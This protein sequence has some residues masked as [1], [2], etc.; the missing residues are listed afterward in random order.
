MIRHAAAL[1][2]WSAERRRQL[3]E[4]L[5][6]SDPRQA[7]NYQRALLDGSPQD[8]PVLRAILAD[9]LAAHN[10]R[11][12]QTT[13]D[14]LTQRDPTN[15]EAWYDH[16]IFN[17]VANPKGALID[18]QRAAS[19]PK[20]HLRAYADSRVL[21]AHLGDP[22]ATRLLALGVQLT[23]DSQW[24][25]AEYVLGQVVA[26]DS[27]SAAAQALIGLAQD[28]QGRDGWLSIQ[29]ALARSADDPMVNYAA[30]L[31]WRIMGDYGAALAALSRAE[32]SDPGSPALAA[33]IGTIYRLA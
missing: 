29:S 1:T 32:A 2:G 19:D 33:E 10:W 20:V 22:P 5:A 4:A 3:A 25:L 24:A 30:G 14:S 28:E 31:H 18:L 13:L 23:G 21:N 27:G 11:D 7:V 8:V 16:A 15:G 6:A 26:W 9:D 17:A 12:A